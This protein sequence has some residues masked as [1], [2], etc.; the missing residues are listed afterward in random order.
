MQ[1][2]LARLVTPLAVLA[3]VLSLGAFVLG[4]GAG[5]FEG[6]G[7]DERMSAD[8]AARREVLP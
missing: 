7:G 3:L 6:P 1:N 5:V 4:Y 8:L 2:L